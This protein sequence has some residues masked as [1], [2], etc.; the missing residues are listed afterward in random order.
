MK[1]LAPQV[2]LFLVV[3]SNNSSNSMRMVEVALD[4]GA[5][6]AQLVEDA[7]AIDDRWLEGVR[8][9]GLSSGASVPEVL[10]QQT[11]GWLAVRGFTD[12]QEVTAADERLVFA[13]PQDIRRALR[14]AG[15]PA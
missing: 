2:E 14:A 15:M 11:L 9:V 7:T 3:G 10:V 5:P 1:V 8:T 4:A 12:I 13:L 6:A